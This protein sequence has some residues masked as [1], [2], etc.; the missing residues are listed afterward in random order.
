M[1]L[2]AYREDEY[3]FLHP[4]PDGLPYFY[5]Y[6]CLLEVLHL[7]LPLNDF[8]CALLRR[9]N[10]APSQLDPNSWA[11]VKA[12]EILCMFFNIRPTVPMFMYIFQM[13]LIGKIGWVSLNSIFSKFL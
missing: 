10:V 3:L 1:T 9:L 5:I 6:R 8:Q 11:M 7:T 12:F 4:S 2:V 13:N